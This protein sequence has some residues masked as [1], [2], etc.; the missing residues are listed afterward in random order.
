MEVTMRL[1]IRLLFLC[2]FI[3]SSLF[4]N[5]K[6]SKISASSKNKRVSQV[7]TESSQS[8]TFERIREQRKN[9]PSRGVIVRFHQWPN[10]KWK[11]KILTH[12]KK[13]NLKKVKTIGRFKVWLFEWTRLSTNPIKKSNPRNLAQVSLKPTSLALSVCRDLPTLS[14]I[15]YCEPDSMLYP[16]ATNEEQTEARAFCV[17]GCEGDMSNALSL[18][19]V[20][21]IQN[22]AGEKC[23]FISSQVNLTEDSS[24]SDYWAQ[25]L[26]GSDLLREELEKVPPPEVE[27]YIS[28][29]DT[30]RKNR[31]DV[32]VKKLVSDKGD[33]AILPDLAN[34]MS[35][36]ETIDFNGDYQS[37]ADTL[38][39]EGKV[40]SFINNSMSWVGDGD[41]NSPV[42][43]AFKAL[44]LPYY[45]TFKALSPPSIVV[46]SSGNDYPRPLNRHKARSS[47]DFDAIAVG[48]FSPNGMVSE[49]SSSGEE[50]HILAPSDQYL[51]SSSES[52]NPIRFGGTSGAAPLVTGSLAGFEWLS[53][54]HPTSEEA[55]FLLEKTALPT[56]HSYEEP[57]KNGVGLLNVYK[58]GMVGKRL[59]E[60]CKQE[61]I[62]C[63][64][65]EIQ[66]DEN[67]RFSVDEEKI[68][69]DV[70][71]VFPKCTIGATTQEISERSSC[72]DKEKTFKKLRKAVLL[73]PGRIELWQALSCIYKQNGFSRNERAV[74]MMALSSAIENNKDI[75]DLLVSLNG[76]EL[77]NFSQISGNMDKR[78][79]LALVIQSLIKNKEPGVREEIARFAVDLGG[80]EGIRM[81]RN[82]ARD[83]NVEV[84]GQ[85]ARVAVDLG[86]E[87]GLQILGDL[88]RDPDVSRQAIEGMMEIG[89]R[90][91]LLQILRDLA[92]DEDVR[93]RQ[94]VVD[95][96]RNLGGSEELN[97]LQDMARDKDSR[98]RERVAFQMTLSEIKGLSGQEERLQILRD[99]AKD[100]DPPVR[101][102]AFLGI[103]IAGEE[104]L[105][106]LGDLA[107]NED[108]NVSRQAI[109][110]IVRIGGERGLQILGGLVKEEG[111]EEAMEGI[112]E[113]GQEENLREKSLEVLKDLS[114]NEDPEVRE[115]A[116]KALS[117]LSAQ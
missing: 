59:K 49:F 19:L 15:K 74:D 105:Q 1:S 38:I 46:I 37:I 36:F 103:M 51:L 21:E 96:A 95:E 94:L 85:A 87:E 111:S 84:R 24:L 6:T 47:K 107:R 91:D 35:V 22:I 77:Q 16:D 64:Q 5:S 27:N 99:L 67:Y 17:D 20:N 71:G 78:T 54:Y 48:S 112:A 2:T 26:I 12:L 81:L 117:E 44:S 60:K 53:G 92:K 66:K 93:L 88:A 31:H 79:K 43:D 4:V 52:G 55:K 65:R 28:V 13:H 57:R 58:L 70:A 89:G 101:G 73:N 109:K 115:V 113:L 83:E 14:I 62:S 102:R 30:T 40:P 80:E 68:K 69:N 9:P 11:K 10:N 90:E 61:D 98:V 100:E 116:T 72:E 56:I 18:S 8:L 82:L 104:G 23:D 45:D 41:Q 114:K 39:S 3:L 63:F 42:Y 106:V 25:E 7:K 110:D 50:V 32:S 29:F 75:N 108:Y 97:I 33:Q 34:K 76:G 86:G